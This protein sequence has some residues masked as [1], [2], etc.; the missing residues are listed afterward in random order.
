MHPYTYTL[1]YIYFIR[2]VGGGGQL[3]PLGTAAANKNIVP[4]P[5]DYDDDG[6]TGGMPGRGNRSTWRKPTPVPFCP[7]Q[8]PYA[9]RTRTGPPR[10]EA[11]D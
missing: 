11:G 4:A 7:P 3:G 1:T 2:I 8:N 9:A 6:E 5:G 10:W